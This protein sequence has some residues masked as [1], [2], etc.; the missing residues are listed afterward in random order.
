MHFKWSVDGSPYALADQ[1]IDL[2]NYMFWK[3]HGWIDNVWERYRV[4][5]KLAPDELA[6]ND[7]L[8]DQCLEMHRLGLLFD[9]TLATKPGAPRAPETGY[10]VD[11]VR[12]ILD[13]KCSGCHS[14]SAPVGGLSFAKELGSSDVVK[15][16]V[17]INAM[18]GGMFKRVVAGKPEQSWLYLK[19]SDMAKSAGCS[20]TCNTQSMPPTGQVEL[21]AAQLDAL[22]VWIANGA[23]SP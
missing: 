5:Q 18:S 13:S 2:G 15:Q 7:S 22:R 4:A 14:G 11:N 10:F 12:P 6:L 23:A 1:V 17:D 19:V 20:G 16:L 9:P 3:L 8:R 21:T